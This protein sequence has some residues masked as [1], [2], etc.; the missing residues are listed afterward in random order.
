MLL[1][2]GWLLLE[3]V[4]GPQRLALERVHIVQEEALKSEHGALFATEAGTLV[5]LL[6]SLRSVARGGVVSGCGEVTTSQR[7]TSPPRSMGKTPV[8]LS[9]VSADTAAPA[10]EQQKRR[11]EEGRHT[12][13]GGVEKF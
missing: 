3:L 13:G 8:A 10:A 9:Q 11:S 12:H 1:D 7:M 2:D 5:E 6:V 4:V